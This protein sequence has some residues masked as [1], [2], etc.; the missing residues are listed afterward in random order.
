MTDERGLP[1]DQPVGGRVTELDFTARRWIGA[2]ALDT[3]FTDLVRDG[4]GMA[5]V[6][7]TTPPAAGA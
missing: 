7:S 2:T 1:T 3:A 5:R 6:E 4:D